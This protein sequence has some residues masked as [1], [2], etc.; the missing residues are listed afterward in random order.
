MNAKELYRSFL[1][2]S[3][4][5][6]GPVFTKKLDARVRFH[7]KIN[8]SLPVS[9]ADKLCYL[10]LFVDNDQKVICSDKYKVREYIYEKGLGEILVPLCGGPFSSVKDIDYE[11]FPKQFV[12]KAAHGC[13]MN[14]I[15]DNKDSITEEMVLKLA[16]RWLH[17]EYPRA[18][19]EPHYKKI[20]KRVIV[21][22]FLQNAETIIDYKFHCFHGKPDFILVCGN[23]AKGVQKRLYTLNWEPIDEMVGSEK[24]SYEFDRPNK[25][26]EMLQ[27]SKI[28]SSDFDFVRVDLY[29][30]RGKIYFGELTFSPASGVLPNFSEKFLMEKGKLLDI[31]DV[32]KTSKERKRP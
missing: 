30:I 23:R 27:I 18:C 20:P 10:E 8:L 9:L 29:E 4:A 22:E 31:S 6:T 14:L 12:M 32:F 11:K 24:G 25:L 21:E 2:L 1:K 28:L 17:E 19:I 3:T 26:E 5:V 15:C 7:R 13:G 16:D